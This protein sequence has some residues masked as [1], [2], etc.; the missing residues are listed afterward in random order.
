MTIQL[1]VT[2]EERQLLIEM[3]TE[4]IRVLHT[5]IHHA[6]TGDAKHYLWERLTLTEKLLKEME[7]AEECAAAWPT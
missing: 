1:T 5:E 4:Q 7:T 6:A 2:E 3:L